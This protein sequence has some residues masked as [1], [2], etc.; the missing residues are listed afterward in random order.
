MILD[1]SCHH[2]TDILARPLNS[3][4]ANVDKN[5]MYHHDQPQDPSPFAMLTATVIFFVAFVAICSG[6]S[7]GSSSATTPEPQD[8]PP[9]YRADEPND[10]FQTPN[11]IV[12]EAPR[13]LVEGNIHH[14]DLDC[15]VITGLNGAPFSSQMVDISFDYAAGWDM[16][17]SVSW[18]QSDG[19]AFPLWGAYDEWG[20]GHLSTTVEVPPGAAR[21]WISIGQRT[22]NSP[23][24]ETR[25]TVTVETF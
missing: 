13:F 6:C 15:M 3:V 24:D 20:L 22:L 7:S 16:E 12:P 8:P 5:I 1:P 18:E 10:S 19:F 11:V 23:P 4:S 17:V 25:Y 9:C 21:L 2:R 14:L